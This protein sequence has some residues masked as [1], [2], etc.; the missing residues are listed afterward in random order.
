M[1]RDRILSWFRLSPKLLGITGRDGGAD[2]IADAQR[3]FDTKTARPL[4]NKLQK[5]ISASLTQ[6]WDLDYSID[7]EYADAAGGQVRLVSNFA[8]IPG[9]TVDEVR[10]YAN[11]GP[12]PDKTIGEMTLNLPGEDAGT[13][14]PGDTP[15]S[16]GFP[17]RNL[18]GEAGRP[19][20]PSNTK[21][22]RATAARYRR[23]RPARRLTTAETLDDLMASLDAIAAEQKAIT[24]PDGATVS[25]GNTLTHERRPRLADPPARDGGGR[26]HGRPGARPGRRRARAGARPAG[27]DRGQGRV[28]AVRPGARSATRP[29]GAPS[30]R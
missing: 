13:G 28:Q 15:T 24:A 26:D 2:K 12:H 5:K 20:K 29:R 10:A 11:L 30:R 17:D 21:P 3:I 23:G 4:M 7:Y 19:P 9:V 8:S 14:Q 18:T 25:V 16:N 1:S 27:R 22:S 6:A